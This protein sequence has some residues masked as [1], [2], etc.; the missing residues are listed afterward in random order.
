[1]LREQFSRSILVAS[2]EDAERK[3]LQWNIGYTQHSTAL[4]DIRLLVINH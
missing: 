2:Y 1:M 4:S 3:L